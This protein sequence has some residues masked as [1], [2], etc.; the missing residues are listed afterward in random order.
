MMRRA[1][2]CAIAACAAATGARAAPEV[3]FLLSVARSGPVVVAVGAHGT[4]LRSGDDAAHFAPAISPAAVTLTR[5][6]A[7][8]N[9][10][11][12]ATGFGATILRSTDG[13]QNWVRVHADPGGDLPIF[14]IAPAGPGYLAVGGFGH[15]YASADGAA[16]HAA[17]I[18]AGDDAPH[19]NDIIAAD[20]THLLITG[21]AGLLLVSADAG[22]HWLHP[23]SPAQ[24]SLFGALALTPARWLAYGL[25]GRL[26]ASDDAGAHWRELAAD[27]DAELLGGAVLPDGR[28]LLV[29]N[30]GAVLV[31]DRQARQARRLPPPGH[32]GA[33]PNFADATVLQDGRIL[34][35]GDTGPVGLYVP[36]A[37]AP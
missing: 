19:L 36:A 31:V 24:A 15:A 26:L 28:A 33:A 29:G 14:G 3:P 8:G 17:D 9:G 32:A 21:E 10:V 22:A 27:A 5:V 16:W 23:A 2:L 11:F 35:V 12:F 18:P 34:A 25:R 4:I 7:R 6:L 30:R 1:L 13:G 20:A 37:G